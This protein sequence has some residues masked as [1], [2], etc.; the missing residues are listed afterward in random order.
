VAASEVSQDVDNDQTINVRNRIVVPDPIEVSDAGIEAPDLTTP[1]TCPKCQ[2]EMGK[3]HFQEVE[4]DRCPQCHG[5]WFDLMEHEELKKLPGA[6]SIDLGAKKA[7]VSQ[8]PRELDCPRCKTRMLITR[9]PQ[10]PHL[11]FEKCSICYGVFFDAGEFKDFKDVTILEFL[12]G[13]FQ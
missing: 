6:E 10:Q 7:T 11:V 3:V 12:R 2:V 9:D 8:E 1:V 5:L 13:L 4:V